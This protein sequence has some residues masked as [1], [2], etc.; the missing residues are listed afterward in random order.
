MKLRPIPSHVIRSNPR[1]HTHVKGNNLIWVTPLCACPTL[2]RDSRP[3]TNDGYDDN[4]GGH[5]FNLPDLFGNKNY[6]AQSRYSASSGRSLSSHG[7]CRFP[8]CIR[9]VLS[10]KDEDKD[11]DHFN[12]GST[13]NNKYMIPCNFGI[14]CNSPDRPDFSPWTTSAGTQPGRRVSSVSQS[15]AH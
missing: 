13:T 7:K 4:D 11:E 14:F 3:A 15:V 12:K 1:V 6:F 5:P 10:F 2:S 8:R 9:Y